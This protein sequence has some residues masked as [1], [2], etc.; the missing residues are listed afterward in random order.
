M[1]LSP[2]FIFEV[3]VYLKKKVKGLNF[4]PEDH[5]Q[6]SVKTHKSL[7]FNWSKTRGACRGLSG[8]PVPVWKDWVHRRAPPAP[9][10]VNAL[11]GLALG[12]MPCPSN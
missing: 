5:L 7:L 12:N 8:L 9:S 1:H 6:M 10:C 11:T 3:L 2:S 4:V